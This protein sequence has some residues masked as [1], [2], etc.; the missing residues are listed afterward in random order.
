MAFDKDTDLSKT[1]YIKIAREKPVRPI[2]LTWLN[3][4]GAMNIIF[5]LVC[6]AAAYAQNF[7][8]AGCAAAAGLLVTWCGMAF[9]WQA[10]RQMNDKIDALTTI[11]EKNPKSSKDMGL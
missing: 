11:I 2:N 6:V 1:G 4:F 10:I 5:S 9:L 7:V 3:V 8:S